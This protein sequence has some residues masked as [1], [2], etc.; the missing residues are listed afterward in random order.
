MMRLI[1]GCITGIIVS[2]YLMYF[3][4]PLLVTTHSNFATIVNASDPTVATSY[5]MGAGFYAILPFIPVIVTV[6]LVFSYA[7]KTRPDE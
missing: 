2:L 4:F 6:F 7:L 1:V 3:V 5:T